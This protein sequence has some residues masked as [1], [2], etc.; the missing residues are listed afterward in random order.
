MNELKGQC[1][2]AQR[3]RTIVRWAVWSILGTI[4]DMTSHLNHPKMWDLFQAD[5]SLQRKSGIYKVDLKEDCTRLPTCWTITCKLQ[6][7]LG[8]EGF[9]KVCFP[10][11]PCMYVIFL[12]LCRKLELYQRSLEDRRTEKCSNEFFPT[13]KVYMLILSFG[14]IR[15]KN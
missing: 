7:K 2:T 14:T 15:S 11:L 12:T 10:Y 4:V 1:P 13:I 8:D 9:S 6:C 3:H 5:Q